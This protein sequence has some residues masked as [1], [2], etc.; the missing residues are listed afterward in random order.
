M[1]CSTMR[2]LTRILVAGVLVLAGQAP[3]DAVTLLATLSSIKISARPG[4]VQTREFRLTL[5]ANQ[6]TTRFKAHM[7]DW[8][9][10]EDGAQSHYAEPGTLASSCGRWVTLNPVE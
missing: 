9:R 6:P 7:Q 8:W 5:D 4:A 10:S 2:T 1:G 3:A